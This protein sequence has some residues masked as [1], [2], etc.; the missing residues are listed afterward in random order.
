MSKKLIC[1]AAV[2]LM[3]VI[4]GSAGAQVGKGKILA[5]WWLN[6]NGTNVSDLTGN[7]GYP[8]SPTGS[9]WLNNWYFYP[10][11][12]D[13]N[14]NYGS[15][16]RAYISPPQ[17]GAYT[18]YIASD[19]ASQLWLS[20]DNT[21]ANTKMICQVTGWTNPGDWTGTQGSLNTTQV[22]QPVTLKANQQYYMETL[23]KEGGGGDFVEV[24]WSGPVIG[25][26]P[27]LVDGKYCTAFIRNPEP[28]FK[29]QSPTPANGATEVTSPLFTWTAGATAVL[30]DVYVGTS[31]TLGA[32]DY[33]GPW[34]TAMY[35]HVPGLTPGATYYWRVDEIDAAGTKTTG[36]VWSFTVAPLTAHFPS[37]YDGALW[38]KTALTLSWTAGQG[39]VKH[40]PFISDDKTAVTSGAASAVKPDQTT[41]SLAVTGLK[42]NDTYYWRVDEIDST[43]KVNAG[44]VWSFTTV[45]AAGGAVAEYFNNISLSGKPT[46]VTIVPEINFTWA[47]GSV[48]GV[49]SP[50]PN[51]PTTNFSARYTAQLNVP[52]SGKYTLYDASDDGARLFLNGVQLTNGWV[53]RGETEDASAPQDLVAGQSYVIVM[54]YYQATGGAA[55]RLRWAG[56]GIAKDIIP[57]GALQIPQ[58]AISPSPGNN[59][60]ETGD[61]PVFTWTAGPKAVT[62]NVYLSTDQTLVANSDAKALVASKLAVTTFTP[63][64][65][66]TWNT[67]YYWKVD[68]IAADG[69]TIKGLVWNFTVANFVPINLDQATLTY[70]NSKDP[71]VSQ[72][73]FNVP[74]DLTAG[75]AVTDLALR[76]IGQLASGGVTYDAASQTYTVTGAGADIWGNA[77]QFQYVFKNLAGDGTMVARVTNIGPGSNTW[78]KAGVMIRQSLAVGSTHAAMVLS[79]NSDGTA[80]NGYSYQRRLVAD[81]ASSSN[82]GTAPAIK[83]PYWVQI[84]RKG[85]VFTASVSPD[86]KTWTQVGT[87]QTIVMTDPVFIGLAVT[88][89]QA[90][91]NRTMTFDNVSTTGNVTPAAGPFV[92]TDDIGLHAASNDLSPL[93]VAV[94]DKAGKM[95]MVINPNAAAVQ[96]TAWDL[97]RIPLTA[98]VGADVKNATKLFVGVGNGKPDGFGVMNFRDI[99]ILQ[100]VVLPD[101]AAVDVTQPTDNIVGFPYYTGSSPAAEM[102]ANVIDGKIATKY[103]SFANSGGTGGKTVMPTGF[104]VTPA[105]GY[106]VVTGLTFT[107]A[108]DAPE[109][110]P[111]AFELYGS[112]VGIGGPWVLI[113]KGAIDDFARPLE[114]PRQTKGVTPIGFVNAAAFASYRVSITAVRNPATANSMQVN[115]VELLGVPAAQ[116]LILS[117]VRANGQSDTR[118]PIGKYDGNTQSL[119]T[120]AGGLKDGNLCFS[121]RTYP[122]SKTPKELA[123]AEYVRT[124]N[125]DKNNSTVM[126]TV[127]L[128]KA[129]TVAL[130]C[131]DRITPQQASVDSVVAGFAAPGKFK[132]TGLKLFVHENSTTDTPMSVFS[133]DLPAGIYVFFAQPS[134]GNFYTIGA[135]PK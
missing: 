37:P 64:K 48:K 77:D 76:F 102:P 9:M 61:T 21:S 117:A 93:F 2:G 86:G 36:D 20:T 97:W 123:G 34:P 129:A 38:R 118:D 29:A 19:D 57:Q 45:D 66:L 80:G 92:V 11:S 35:F 135:I 105:M 62:H 53:N 63:A 100:P 47:S 10:G 111:I 39:A 40:R 18:F 85:N 74:A 122:W 50:D 88:A 90:G 91:Q 83:P 65:A 116:P 32:K 134:S 30:H 54:E 14:D 31:A 17:D 81:A 43:G 49:N 28:L 7:A 12:A 51:I 25:T 3:L 103:L 124:F 27:T 107:T 70:D 1:L 22:S 23:H 44:P 73:A 55:A 113:A 125:S 82:D 75:G 104:E 59:A 130:T 72:L 106:T 95:A 46:V 133:A 89:H 8:N 24:A 13:W 131:D 15:R 120:Q 58:V 26:A 115:E 78:A 33:M 52:V 56:P 4:A 79:A 114:W 101:P 98:F 127:T 5:E 99:R 94:Q 87:P 69:S 119:A 84:A 96:E 132:N 71:F 121:D 6:V 42:T 60:V 110:D 16:Q 112:N 109:R 108:N 128:S 68:E 67:T 126:Y 41:A